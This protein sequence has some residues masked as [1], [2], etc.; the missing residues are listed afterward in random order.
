VV[1]G[2]DDCW[3]RMR[4]EMP[5]GVRKNERGASVSGT[6]SCRR[7]THTATAAGKLLMES[8]GSGS[9]RS[10]EAASERDTTSRQTAE[11]K[12]AECA[13]RAFS[14]VAPRAARAEGKSGPK[15]LVK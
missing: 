4:A 2:A 9:V 14:R 6:T 15:K 3:R 8:T 11:G 1:G 13:R 5:T 7:E 12:P 10:S